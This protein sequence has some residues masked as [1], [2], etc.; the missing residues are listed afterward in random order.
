MVFGLRQHLSYGSVLDNRQSVSVVVDAAFQQTLWSV[1]PVCSGGGVVQGTVTLFFS[2][3]HLRQKQ[4]S[5]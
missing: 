4:T 2:P 1:A 5:E 3:Y